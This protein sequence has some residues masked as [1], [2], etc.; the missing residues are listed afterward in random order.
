M[1]TLSTCLSYSTVHSNRS[2][3]DAA[4]YSTPRCR[5][6]IRGS[7][8]S[9]RHSRSRRDNAAPAAKISYSYDPSVLSAVRPELIIIVSLP[10][11]LNDFFFL[12]PQPHTVEREAWLRY[13]ALSPTTMAH[14]RLFV[15]QIASFQLFKSALSTLTVSTCSGNQNVAPAFDEVKAT[16][17]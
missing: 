10:S 14:E 7:G 1:P 17:D 9:T 13:S 3:K 15:G 2:S 8:V 11:S 4:A 12:Y 5:S 6:I 16:R